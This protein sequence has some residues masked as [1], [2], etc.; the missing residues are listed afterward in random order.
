MTS[1]DYVIVGGGTA[2]AILAA[3]LTEDPAVTVTLVEWGPSDE[4]EPRATAL[5]RWPELFGSEYDLDYRSVPQARG[6]SDIRQTRMRLL[7]GCSTVNTM[8]AWRPP[9]ADLREWVTLG[10]S[11]WGPED[12][13]P[14]FDRLRTP[15]T[16]VAPADRNPLLADI[17]TAAAKALDVPE[18]SSW[19]SEPYVDGAGFFEVGYDP[20]TGAR[21]SSSRVY[22][23]PVRPDRPNL[24]LVLRTRVTKVL[25]DEGRATG[26]RGLDEHGEPVTLR[27]HREVILCAGAIDT[28]RLLLL[29]GIGP[30]GVLADAGVPLVHDLPGVGENLQDH[31]DALVVWETVD[32]VPPEMASGW[33]AGVLARID[34]NGERPDVVMLMGVETWAEHL[35]AEGYDLPA[36]TTSLS[37]NVAKP[38]SRGRI[39]ITSA[40]PDAAPS[41]D[42]RSFT[43]PGGHDEAVLVAGLRM[44]RRIAATEPMASRV[45]REV[46]P[47]PDVRSD[48]DLSAI[49]RR[50]HQTVYHVCGT[51]RMGAADDPLAVVDPSLRV[52]GLAGLRIADASVFPT[53]PSVN[54]MCTVMMLAERAADVLRGSY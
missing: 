3:R 30:A 1:S 21:S 19:N 7:G 13:G 45:V 52:R 33:D 46:F 2:G 43:D 49:A 26:V 37:P 17:V 6:N 42:Y 38:A 36:H 25:V 47:G 29:S 12:F 41:L 9:D 51:A 34:E 16:P 27:A 22:L 11:G 4:D 35:T 14:Y 54:P 5:R 53:V 39:W 20:A 50:T 31:A 8:I 24:R 18:R 32:P 15:I 28:P 10:A 44:A 40:D 48:E 23:H